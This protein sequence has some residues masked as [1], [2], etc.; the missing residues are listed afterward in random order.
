MPSLSHDQQEI[1]RKSE[2]T[3]LRALAA[4]GQMKVAESLGVS[5]S[6]ISR[7]KSDGKPKESA[8]W[9]AAHGLKAVPANY[10]CYDPKSIDA[11]LTLAKERMAQLE[12]PD[13]LLWED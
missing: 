7:Q 5:E 13:H 2:S 12:S 4:V 11:L 6:T 3:I 9:L 10:K 8:A 1:A